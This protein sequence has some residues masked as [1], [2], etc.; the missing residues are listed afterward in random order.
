MYSFVDRFQLIHHTPSI[1][2]GVRRA[3]KN[4]RQLLPPGGARLRFWYTIKEG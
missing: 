4:V 3:K 1:R 2:L